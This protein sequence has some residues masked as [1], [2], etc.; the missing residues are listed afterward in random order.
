MFINELQK[1]TWLKDEHRGESKLFFEALQLK[2]ATKL[3][4]IKKK[5]R[6]YQEHLPLTPSN[7]DIRGH[8]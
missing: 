4:T 8:Q 6:I 1:E 3:G 2:N 7:E 5:N